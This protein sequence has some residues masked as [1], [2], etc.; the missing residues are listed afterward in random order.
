MNSSTN[1]DNIIDSI[2]VDDYKQNILEE[3]PTELFDDSNTE[4]SR[5]S[6]GTS[7]TL[8]PEVPLVPKETTQTYGLQDDGTYL[9][10]FH[11]TLIYD[12]TRA[13]NV[14]IAMLTEG[15]QCMSI[16]LECD[17]NTV[18]DIC[19]YVTPNVVIISDHFPESSIETFKTRGFQK[20]T[21]L[22]DPEL[23][24][25]TLAFKP[26]F[27]SYFILDH[28]MVATYPNYKSS[29]NMI[30]VSRGR[31]FH[32]G[33]VADGV[34]AIKDKVAVIQKS[35]FVETEVEALINNGKGILEERERIAN[36]LITS[37]S[38]VKYKFKNDKTYNILLIPSQECLQEIR[39][40]TPMNPKVTKNEI[41][42]VVTF[43]ILEKSIIMSATT[44]NEINAMAFLND[45]DATKIEGVHGCCQG[46]VKYEKLFKLL[47]VDP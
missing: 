15:T 40:L 26:T 27:S 8:P 30:N 12:D 41:N 45:L 14:V 37:G 28:L 39:D 38:I 5:V 21:M 2:N 44:I 17:Y 24:F 32:R 9:T 4:P 19:Y 3:I 43:S 16:P 20:V 10:P 1:T 29:F 22:K 46:I 33:L 34:E 13:L 11:T 35:L 7:D 18:A 23:Y 36:N 6:D 31:L 47:T 25:D 42:L